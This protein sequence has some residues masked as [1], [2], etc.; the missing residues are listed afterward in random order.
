MAAS[1][2][3]IPPASCLLFTVLAPFL[4]ARF[5]KSLSG[6]PFRRRLAAG[7]LVCLIGLIASCRA[8]RDGDNP[9]T[10]GTPP[11]TYQ[12][13][14]RGESGNLTVSTTVTLVVS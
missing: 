12:I 9:P 4:G 6:R 14:V 13:T 7:A 5:R 10:N 2:G 3:F 1:T 8:G 11:G